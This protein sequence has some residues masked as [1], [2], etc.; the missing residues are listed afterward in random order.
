MNKRFWT[1]Y[2][3]TFAS[4]YAYLWLMIGVI[5]PYFSPDDTFRISHDDVITIMTNDGAEVYIYTESG[6]QATALMESV[7][8]EVPIYTEA[9]AKPGH[10]SGSG[11]LK[12]GQYTVIGNDA[13]LVF[14]DDNLIFYKNPAREQIDSRNRI[15]IINGLFV[16]LWVVLTSLFRIHFLSNRY[17]SSPN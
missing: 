11:T 3:L 10:Y 9:S 14:A 7:T 12:T 15:I 4:L 16:I 6:D 2:I 8:R 17:Q 5:A 1:T 13:T